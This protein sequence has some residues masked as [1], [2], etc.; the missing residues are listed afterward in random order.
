MRRTIS[1][2]LTY[3]ASARNAAE[4]ERCLAE[5]VAQAACC[6]DWRTLL[7]G[8]MGLPL[9]SRERKTEIADRTLQLAEA[10]RD[11]WGFRDVATMRATALDDHTGARAALDAC[12]TVFQR[13][14][15]DVLGQT[16]ELLGDEV[17]ARGYEWVL[18]G[19]GFA[20]TLRDTEGLRRCLEAGCEMARAHNSADDLCAV[21]SE[22]ARCVDREEGVALLRDAELLAN[23][24]S[25]QPWTLANA[26]HALGDT[27][28]VHR[29]LD[30]ALEASTTTDAALHV[31]SAWASHH[32]RAEIL[33]A[34]V[35]AQEL[36]TSAT[37]WLAIAESAFDA[38]LGEGAIRHA[39]ARAE[40]LAPTDWD[41]QAGVSRAYAHWLHDDGA[42]A[43][44]GPRGVRPEA[45]RAR[46]RTLP[47]WP[48][49]ASGLFDWLRERVTPE[50]LR[51]IANADYGAD[52]EKH[53]AA[54]R[55]ICSTGLVPRALPWEPHEV[56]ALSRWAS[57][58]RVDHLERALCAT[59][60]CLA[61][62]SM[63]ELV[64]NGP[65]L[66]ESCLALG[67]EA[68]RLAELFFAWRSETEDSATASMDADDAD[69]EQPIALLLLF[70]VRTASV[71]T[72]PC[73]DPL[74]RMLTDHPSYTLGTIAEWIAGSMRAS[75]WHDLLARILVPV[76]AAHPPV[77][78]VLRGLGH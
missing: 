9:A 63:E 55:D 42:A 46:V 73:L 61:P 54:L 47:G 36:A 12:A 25:A 64:T 62:G 34:H 33:R 60:L 66:A 44:V 2:W 65:I 78:V 24:G 1:D 31:A 45:S 6:Y 53:L 22:W 49:S 57:G 5:A 38:G 14:R 30:A 35:R 68:S 41:A 18:L 77:A 37:D 29:V 75:L 52:A 43:R 32:E 17:L 27:T 21:A 67:P 70:V 69:P 13:R 74:A 26:W 58:E 15:T 10:E 51:G 23:N 50:I 4:V 19:Q 48:T 56:L 20:E 7:G 71:P 28:A 8:A 11:V 40:T 3:A 39:V 76:A 72:D 16:A 59:L